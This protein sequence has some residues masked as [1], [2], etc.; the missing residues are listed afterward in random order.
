MIITG[1]KAS[2]KGEISFSD[3]LHCMVNTVNNSVLHISSFTLLN[4]KTNSQGIK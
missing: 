1:C 3:L 4:D 2:V